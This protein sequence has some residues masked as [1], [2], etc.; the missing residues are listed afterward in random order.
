MTDAVFYSESETG[1]PAPKHSAVPLYTKDQGLPEVVKSSDAAD[2]RWEMDFSEATA[3]DSIP[4]AKIP[5]SRLES[6][7]HASPSYD[8]RYRLYI[9]VAVF[10]SQTIRCCLAAVNM[11]V[12]L[13][14]LLH[15]NQA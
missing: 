8:P 5:A 1:S 9:D 15:A 2:D 3:Q 4:A 10:D 7:V 11:Q 14:A 13:T 6:K 12:Q